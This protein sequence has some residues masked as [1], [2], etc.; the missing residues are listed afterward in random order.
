MTPTVK[1]PR[2]RSIQMRAVSLRMARA[3]AVWLLGVLNN[4]WDEHPLLRERLGRLIPVLR[5]ITH[6]EP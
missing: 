6:R 5:D 1:K 4:M 2:A 3:D